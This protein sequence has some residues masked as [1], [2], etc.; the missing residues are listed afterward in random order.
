MEIIEIECVLLSFL[1][2][3]FVFTKWRIYKGFWLVPNSR[4]ARLQGMQIVC[5]IPS[6]FQRGRGGGG[7]EKEKKTSWAREEFFKEG[8]GKRDKISKSFVNEPKV[9]ICISDKE[10][11][12]MFNMLKK[13]P[14]L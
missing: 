14:I 1:S 8:R 13:R 5:L 10:R 2:K 4:F 9:R 7:E 12:H 6:R 3:I 11:L